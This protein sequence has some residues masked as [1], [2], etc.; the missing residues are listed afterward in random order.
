M[1]N[2]VN[3]DLDLM[4]NLSDMPNRKVIDDIRFLCTFESY[5]PSFDPL[6]VYLVNLPRKIMRI[7]FFDESFDFS[8]VYDKF[9]RV[10]TIVD[11][12]LVFSYILSFGMHA[13]VYDHLLR[14]LKISKWSDLILTKWTG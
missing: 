5:N 6:V 7:T 10:L 3:A 1:S 14:A 9:M 8:K 2:D 4:E 12:L 13:L 11:V